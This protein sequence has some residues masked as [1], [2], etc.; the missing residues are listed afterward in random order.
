VESLPY[1][2]HFAPLAVRNLAALRAR[3]RAIVVDAVEEQLSNEPTVETRNRRAMRANPLAGWELRLGR[4][5]VYYDVED[6]EDTVW[7]NAVGR[8][9]GNR[10]VIAGEEFEL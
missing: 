10:V 7:I 8:K 3:D 9:H 1:Q 2:I 4:L 6:R 5:R